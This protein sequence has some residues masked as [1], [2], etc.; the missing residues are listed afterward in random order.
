[1]R[2]TFLWPPHCILA[3]AHPARNFINRC[4]IAAAGADA[5]GDQPHDAWRG[6]EARCGWCAYN[7][8]AAVGREASLPRRGGDGDTTACDLLQLHPFLVITR[9][10]AGKH[11]DTGREHTQY[12]DSV[13]SI[14]SFR[15]I[16]IR[17]GIV[18]LAID[19]LGRPRAPQHQ[20]E[21]EQEHELKRDAR[22][23]RRATRRRREIV[24]V[25]RSSAAGADAADGPR[26]LERHDVPRDEAEQHEHADGVL[27]PLADC[28]GDVGS[29]MRRVHLQI[30]FVRY[31]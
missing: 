10:T 21:R 28:H 23:T 19:A 5:F 4:P 24:G 16:R 7:I 26:E 15:G 20:N 2:V 14:A 8:A 18:R 17:G 11:T 31:F 3:I 1:M 30:Y 29:T 6:R 12:R 25:G 9:L 27:A 22:E 13:S